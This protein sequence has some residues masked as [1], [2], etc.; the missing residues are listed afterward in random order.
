MP[1]LPSLLPIRI[2]VQPP[3]LPLLQPVLL[4]P[5]PVLQGFPLPVPEV[6]VLRVPDWIR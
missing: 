1:L 5:V 6:H 4:R 3:L 2:P